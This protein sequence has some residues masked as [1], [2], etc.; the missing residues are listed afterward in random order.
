[1]LHFQRYGGVGVGDEKVVSSF[2]QTGLVRDSV[3]I[4]PL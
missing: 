3:R 4:A 2:I 1:V